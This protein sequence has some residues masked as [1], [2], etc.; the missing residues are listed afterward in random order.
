[1]RFELERELAKRKL[2]PKTTG[3]EGRVLQ[4]R[5]EI[6]RRKLRELVANRAAPPRAQP[7]PRAPGR[8]LGYARLEAGL[9][10]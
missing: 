7:R 1:M 4:D 5:W 2:L 10:R 3:E 9:Q 8:A 6:Y